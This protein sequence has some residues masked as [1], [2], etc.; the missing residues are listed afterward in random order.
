M[1]RQPTLQHN[2]SRVSRHSSASL[3][4]VAE[5]TGHLSFSSRY[6]K[7][8][9]RIEDDYK[10]EEKVLG[11]GYNGVVRLAHSKGTENQ[12]YAVKAFKLS[13][14]TAEKR[15]QLDSEV[16]V[17]LEMDHP[18][19]ARLFDVYET[20]SF[21]HL[22]MECLEGGELFD[23]VTERKRFSEHDAAEAARQMLLAVN[24]L[25]TNG[26]V[27]RDLKL[28]NFLFDRNDSDHLKL[29][30]FGFSK[31]WDPNVK[32][33]VSCGTLSYVAPEVLERNYGM[34]CDLWSLGVIAFILIAGYMPFSGSE[35]VQTKNIMLGK[36]TMKKER[37]AN[38]SKDATDFVQR[39]LH[40]NPDIRLT[41]DAAL[42]HPW[43]VKR[44]EKSGVTIDASIVEGLRQFG[45]A[46][47]F[48]RACLEMMA[49]SLSNDE[50]AKVREYFVAMDTN[51]QGTITLQELKQVMIDMFQISDQETHQVFEA[52]DSNQDDTIH[53]SDFL[54]AMMNTHIA[55]H[56]DLLRSAFRRFDTDNSGF[57]TVENLRE[58]LGENEQVENML[59]E[60][61]LLKDN[62]ISY[63]EFVAFVRGTPLCEIDEVATK[64]I[65]GEMARRK[66]E[67]KPSVSSINTHFTQ[68]SYV[69][70]RRFWDSIPG[71]MRPNSLKSPV[72]MEV[73]SRFRNSVGN[74]RLPKLP[75]P[76]PR[77]ILSSMRK[78]GRG[79]SSSSTP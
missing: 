34:Q 17:F 55:M 58:V 33:H 24:Y 4:G 63:A 3:K 71:I 48:R 70:D 46:S 36:Y 21:M 77:V 30:D 11:S 44:Q 31:V 49:W 10:I 51:K 65:D 23:R 12:Q 9:Q 15:A 13:N 27:H 69:G 75:K 47:K 38:I 64:V 67:R 52:M 32:M 78:L 20:N 14:I 18:H 60:A 43:I 40:V 61:D 2:T 16:A 45:Q 56:T 73:T 22:I 59:A 26:I 41:A 53:Y 72:S 6:H 76:S 29:I 74:A 1:G 62:R 8:P 5:R 7:L 37:W 19:V 68:E 25:H 66:A 42:D 57:I 79:G 50:R 54:A 35:E 39:L 28:E